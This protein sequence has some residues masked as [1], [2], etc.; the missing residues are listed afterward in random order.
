MKFVLRVCV[1]VLVGIV[2]LSVWLAMGQ[3]IAKWEGKHSHRTKITQNELS[4]L[5]AEH[6]AWVSNTWQ[7][8]DQKAGIQLQLR[9]ADLTGARLQGA[10]LRSADLQGADLIAANLSGADL[11]QADLRNADLKAADLRKANLRGA[12]LRGADLIGADL[13]EAQTQ[14]TKLE[15]ANLIDTKIEGSFAENSKWQTV[16]ELVNNK[17]ENEAENAPWRRDLTEIDLSNAFL[18]SANLSKINLYEADLRDADMT[19][20]DL[21]GANLKEAVLSNANLTEADLG[22]VIFEPK[23]G[24][25]PDI[26]AVSTAHNLSKLW[27]KESPHALVELREA[28]KKA[29]LLTQERELTYAIKYSRREALWK[30]E[31][32]WGKLESLFN[33]IF[34]E[35]TCKYGMK[36]GRPLMIMLVLIC[37]LTIPYTIVLMWPPQK[38]GIWQLW[39]SDRVRKHLG[40]DDPVR[41]RLGFL[42]A[43]KSGFFFSV[44]SAFSIGWREINVRNWIV[45]LQRQEYIFRATGWVR[46]LSGLQS[47]ISVYL[48]ALWVLT[49]F[50]R[51]FETV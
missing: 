17:E 2:L 3:H 51:L 18:H 37:I 5:V 12:D 42:K 30:Q 28:F 49:Y 8:S 39:F 33:L 26:A 7:E 23:T 22:G 36:P 27:Y 9:G 45:R 16:W 41:L 46:T 10:D 50:G 29:G 21:R 15:Q 4:S 43:L 35:L 44:L 47:L 48:L 40:S 25:L 6:K 34:F 32:V 20:A 1:D 13:R 38:D 14:G 19:Q 24:S 31:G 11:R